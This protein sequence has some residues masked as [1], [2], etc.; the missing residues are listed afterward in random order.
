M[1]GGAGNKQESQP[2][3]GAVAAFPAGLVGGWEQVPALGVS[4][5]FFS[6][7]LGLDGGLQAA[8]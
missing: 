4:A 6:T 7:N 1:M 5:G 8:H 3:G 2:T